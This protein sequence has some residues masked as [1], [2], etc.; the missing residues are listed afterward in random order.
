MDSVQLIAAH[1]ASKDL[2]KENDGQ[3]SSQED[4]ETAGA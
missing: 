4:N 2:R 1:A 3:K